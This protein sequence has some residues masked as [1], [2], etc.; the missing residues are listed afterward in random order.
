MLAGS[1][2]GALHS[3][4]T[5]GAVTLEEAVLALSPAGYWKLDETSGSTATDSSGNGR[6][7][8]YTG[9]YTLAGNAGDDGTS[10]LDLG[11]AGFVTVPDNDAWSINTTGGLTVLALV[12]ANSITSTTRTAIATKGSTPGNSL[13]WGFFHNFNAGNKLTFICWT[14]TG[15]GRYRENVTSSLPS[16]GSWNLVA[17]RTDT[18]AGGGRP[19]MDVNGAIPVSSTNDASGSGTYANGTGSM[20][21]GGFDGSGAD[22]SGGLAHVVVFSS[23]LS[24]ADITAIYDAAVADGWTL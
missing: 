23:K 12:N 19:S 5:S 7:G 13:E 8:T 4:P 22:W 11:G 17:V 14:P 3:V 24:D 21:I 20:R 1:I 6:H 18:V 2:A 10:Y 15:T 16:A 9:T